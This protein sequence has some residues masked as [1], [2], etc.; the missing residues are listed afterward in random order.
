MVNYYNIRV[1]FNY[2]Y[3]VFMHEFFSFESLLN[4]LKMPMKLVL[5]FS[6]LSMIVIFDAI[7]TMTF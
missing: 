5:I 6:L 2:N 7:F 4:N 3:Y 1:T